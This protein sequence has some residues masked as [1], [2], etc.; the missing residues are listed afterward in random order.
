MYTL[1]AGAAGVGI[2][3]LTQPT[4]AK[5]VYTPARI[6]ITPPKERFTRKQ[7][8]LDL[9]HDG[10]TD[11]VFTNRW[12]L[13]S[14]FLAAT[15]SVNYNFR[16]NDV[17]ASTG[18]CAVGLANGKRIGPNKGFRTVNAALGN[19][20]SSGRIVF[21]PWG[22]QRAHY[23][24][25]KFSIRGKTHYGWARFQ[26]HFG[27][28][29]PPGINVLLNGYAYETVPGK[30]IVAGKTK[31]PDVITLP[32]DTHPGTLGRLALGRK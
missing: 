7:F 5:I 19:Y 32:I 25:L 31:G 28:G 12:G 3:A 29:D 30:P 13:S 27:K 16:K 4:E 11:F 2:L 15:F 17:L 24:G 18:A 14:R 26:E 1:A 10:L 20:I 21:C 23:L 9:N 6:H 22:D 8:A